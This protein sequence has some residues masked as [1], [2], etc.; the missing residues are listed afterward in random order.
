[1][2]TSSEIT[3][4]SKFAY[5]YA[6]KVL[7]APL[8][9]ELEKFAFVSSISDVYYACKYAIEVK[10]SRLYDQYHRRLML[11]QFTDKNLS[12]KHTDCLKDYLL[13]VNN[14]IA[15]KK[16]ASEDYFN[17]AN[18][19]EEEKSEIISLV[20][21]EADFSLDVHYEIYSSDHE[22]CDSTLEKIFADCGFYEGINYRKFR[23][24]LSK[25]TSD[26]IFDWFYE[27]LN[28]IEKLADYEYS[29]YEDYYDDES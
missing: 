9:E 8:S 7:E 27:D 2:D 12:Q 15:P 17:Y 6:S 22:S 14:G 1:M 5:I 23:K 26:L 25:P 19:S 21:T 3:F 29:S 24:E 10:K 11:D 16:R 20:G 28:D 4:N 13:F 18:A